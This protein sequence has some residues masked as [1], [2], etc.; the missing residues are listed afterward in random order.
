ME[1]PAIKAPHL[2]VV[3]SCFPYT[4]Q[5]KSQRGETKGE[6]QLLQMV[7][8]TVCVF[9]SPFRD[10]RLTTRHIQIHFTSQTQAHGHGCTVTQGRLTSTKR[11]DPDSPRLH[12][13][14]AL[15]SLCMSINHPPGLFLYWYCVHIVASH[16][17]THVLVWVHTL[18]VKGYRH[19]SVPN[20]VQNI[21][22]WVSQK[23]ESHTFFK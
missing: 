1:T 10:R 12:L 21:Y 5:Y 8:V 15:C 23:L 9:F 20:I 17:G 7:T 19:C 11:M 2:P 3:N 16:G 22:F 4:R 14:F 18:E 13:L 6:L